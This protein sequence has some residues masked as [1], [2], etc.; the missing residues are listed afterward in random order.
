MPT[1]LDRYLAGEHERVWAELVALGPAVRNEPVYADAR[2]VA[3]ETMRRVRYNI[4]TLI[5]RLREIGYQF[6][7]GWAVHCGV[8]SADAA[9]EMDQYEPVLSPPLEDSDGVIA[10]LEAVAGPIPLSLRAFYEIVGG[11]SFIGWH[12]GWPSHRLDPL[13]VYSPHLIFQLEEWK[14]WDEGRQ[15]DG[16]CDLFIAPDEFFKYRYSGGGPYAI[17]LPNLAADA[18]LRY[19]WHHTTFV[20]YLR[21]CFR[22]GG[23]PGWERIEPRPDGDLA[24]GL[25][26]ARARAPRAR[27]GCGRAGPACS[28]C[29]THGSSPFPQ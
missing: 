26:P 19:E 8:L 13:E 24:S 28:E 22:W 10:K 23:F 11:L 12:P 1:Y 5:P 2:A 4:E 6:G 27:P 18:P 20:N 25:I 15:E 17:G 7:H 29:W 3:H 16:T 14:Y 21:I 9:T